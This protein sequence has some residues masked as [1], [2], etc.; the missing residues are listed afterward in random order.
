MTMTVS[1]VAKAAGVS[2]RTLHYYDTI[3]L[4]PP[5]R[6][7][8]AGYRLYG[9]DELMR[10]ERI[11]FYRELDFP[12]EEIAAL[13]EAEGGDDGFAL[14]RQRELLR[15]KRDRLDRVIALIDRRMK[16]DTTMSFKEFD[17]AELDKAREQ[18]RKE[19][20]ERWGNTPEYAESE[21]REAKRGKDDFAR[22]QAE[23]D[24]IFAEFAA[25]RESDPAGAEAR[26]LV[27]K[28]RSHI[29][30]NHYECS[31]AVLAG[32]GQMYTADERF[33]ANLDRFGEGTAQFMSA[34]I[35]EYCAE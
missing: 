11:M 18:Y 16:G 30:A 35:A 6:V 3:G 23:A 24:A 5:K 26:A 1:E 13:M 21:R 25:I 33:T 34:A 12:L 22:I 17:T 32:L 9:E 8:E 4:L 15:L 20:R 14:T 29:S 28:W 7:T 10:L 31:K 19:A 2:V 27:E